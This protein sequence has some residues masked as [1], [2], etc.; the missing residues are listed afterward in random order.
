MNTD[1]WQKIESIFNAALDQEASRRAEFV[2]QACGEDESLRREVESLLA[3]SDDE[4]SFLEEPALQVAAK[5]IA[6]SAT[7][8]GETPG[9]GSQ[10]AFVGRYR[11]IRLLGEGGMGTVYEAEQEEPRRVVALKVIRPGRATA[12]RV[13]RFRHESQALGRLQHPG[14]AQIYDAGTADTGLGP[15]P[16]FA[17]ELVRGESLDRYVATHPLNT[18]EKLALMA[19]ICEGVHHAHQRGLIHRDLKPGNILIDETGQPKILDFGVARLTEAE[20]QLTVQ[21]EVGQI[22]GT[23][24]YMSPEQVMGDPHGIDTRSDVYSLGVILYELLAGKLPYNVRG[25]KLH[26]AVQ[27][28]REA[29]ASP[30]SSFSRE[31][32][33]DIETIVGKALEK[34]KA[35]RYASAEALAADIGR[36]LSDEPIL[37]RPPSASYQLSKFARRHR[38]LVT[39]VATVFLVLVAGIAVS[40]WEAARA[41]AAERRA[42]S[43]AAVAKATS[44]FLENDLLAQADAAQQSGPNSKPDPD[45]KVRTV[46][47]RAAERIAGKFDKQPEVEAS[48]RDTIGKAYTSLGV[49]PAARKQLEQALDLCRKALGVEHPQTLRTALHLG[50]VAWLQGKYPEAEALESQTLE[51]Q[52]RVLGPEHPDTLNTMNGLANIY[53]SQGKDS[54]AEALYRRILEI[55]RHVLGPEQPDTLNTM[56]GLANVYRSQGKYV[57]AEALH[58]Q[59]LDIRRRVLGPE[60]PDT[61]TSMS[62]LAYTYR[63]EGKYAQAEALSKQILEIQ[64]RVL[65]PAHPDTLNTMD[66]LAD[67]YHLN[68]KYAQAEALSK[69]ILEI[70]RRVLGPEHPGTVG[71]MSDL[72]GTYFMQ[73]KYAQA[74][75]LYGQTLEIQ[76]RV[77]GP[78]HPDTLSTMSNLA[79]ACH[80]QGKYAQAE[81]LQSQTLEIRRRVLGPEH[82]ATL[83]TMSNLATTYYSQGKYDEAGALQSQTLEIQRRVLGPEHP[84]TLRTIDG[85]GNTYYVEGKYVQ[86]EALYKQALEIQ[87]RVLRPEHPDTLETMK[88]LAYAY[89]SQGKYEQAEALFSSVL[90]IQRRALGPEQ[91][92]TL[93]T[94]DG[95]GDTY[96]LEGKYV[97][98]EALYTQTLAGRRRTVGSEDLDTLD[99]MADLAMAYRAEGKFAAG[100]ALARE[101]VEGNRKKRPDD[102][103]RFF[104]DSLLGACLTGQ[105]KF[106]EAEPLLL[107]GYRGMDARKEKIGVPEREY[108]DWAR[109]WLVRFYEAW[110]KPETAAKWQ[111]LKG[112]SP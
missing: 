51:I 62:S 67:G 89:L 70:R 19:R 60:H 10:P 41:R 90:E 26:E 109:E 45:L 53:D 42:T 27:A 5:V 107:N 97:Q 43:E 18:P 37:A 111:P 63:S 93:N 44:D 84:D 74:E 65:G 14:I 85:L 68:G 82:P 87:R 91:A 32:R 69:Q 50:R 9:T 96:Y 55:R 7:A 11:V 100:E 75:A 64:R 80:S 49:Y 106:A 8:A 48:I 31:Y 101:A 73:G 95:L 86:A 20:A 103:E 23:L 81:A 47:D 102:W 61:L 34:D 58:N 4:E 54:Q 35:R 12:E 77:L 71:T 22:V 112:T 30:L 92:D 39:A 28:I 72:A 79:A 110:G 16:Y 108:L 1:R 13:R 38:A 33:G 88:S 66:G 104:A 99:A 94:M 59:I 83:V 17:M 25:Q 3:E 36:Y 21:T 24:A 105:K 40:T 2:R 98:A 29:E 56:H 6:S 76:R 57:Q 15:Q 78:E 46:L 52:R